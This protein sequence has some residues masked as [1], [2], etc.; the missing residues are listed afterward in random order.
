MAKQDKSVDASAYLIGRYLQPKCVAR[1][2]ELRNIGGH[3]RAVPT[4]EEISP[5]HYFFVRSLSTAENA[6]LTKP[7]ARIE[8]TGRDEIWLW[9][10]DIHCEQ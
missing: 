3:R 5:G 7:Y 9:V 8:M 6:G 2:Y 4:S 10:G 1:C